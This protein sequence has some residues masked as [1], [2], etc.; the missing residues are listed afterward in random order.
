[1]I[2]SDTIKND[3]SLVRFFHFN[4]SIEVVPGARDPFSKTLTTPAKAKNSL[5]NKTR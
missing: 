4:K 5:L 3:I 2:L 1:M